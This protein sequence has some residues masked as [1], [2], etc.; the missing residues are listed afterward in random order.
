MQNSIYSKYD[1][2]SSRPLTSDIEIITMPDYFTTNRGIETDCVHM[3]LHYE[4]IWFIEGTGIH[5]IDFSENI[6]TN[7]SIFFINPG[8]VHSFDESHNQ[9]GVVIKIN[10]DLFS[11]ASTEDDAYMK[12]ELFNT[13]THKFLNIQQKDS[14]NLQLI[15]DAIQKETQ[16]K[17]DIGHNEYIK[18]LV[19]LLIICIERGC[20]RLNGENNQSLKKSNKVLSE[21]RQ[22]I[23]QNYRNNHNV[24]EYA[25]MLNMST[26]IMT[27]H[28]AEV[29]PLTPSEIINHRIVLEAKRLLR[30]TDLMIKEIG[31]YLGFE[32][33]SYFVKFFKRQTGKLPIDFRNEFDNKIIQKSC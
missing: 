6:V 12:Y 25:S 14:I 9:R 21:F 5:Y 18:A 20:L 2:V 30:F 22:K 4:I 3:H 28:I 27:K 15:I 11:Q 1:I 33:P 23:Q 10:E 32:D 17:G 24:K 19:R 16:R 31:Y 13:D 7:N 29:S 8:Q 26:R